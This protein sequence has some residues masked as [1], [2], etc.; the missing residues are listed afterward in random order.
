VTL[1]RGRSGVAV[2]GSA[3][4]SPPK[5]VRDRAAALARCGRS[6]L[7]CAAHDDGNRMYAHDST[8]T[9][10]RWPTGPAGRRCRR[11]TC[12]LR[13]C[14]WGSTRQRGV[15]PA[16]PRR[17]AGGGGLRAHTSGRAATRAIGH[18]DPLGRRC[19][20]RR[21]P[22]PGVA[23][24]SAASALSGASC[25]PRRARSSQAVLQVWVG[26]VCSG[27]PRV[28]P[29]RR[30]RCTRSAARAAPTRLLV[31][32]RLSD[33]GAVPERCSVAPP[34]VSVSASTWFLRCPPPRRAIA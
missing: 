18:G 31:R 34:V 27:A 32:D 17:A 5:L 21:V 8:R 29:S 30:V 20:R 10:G 16:D 7:Q 3:C 13:L 25:R 19:R 28:A 22:P 4:R 26:G 24:P 33:V 6:C 11:C 14:R 15:A 2:S 9:S 23:P 12:R 1:R